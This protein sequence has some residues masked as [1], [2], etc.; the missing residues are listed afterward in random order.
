M[1]RILCLI[2]IIVFVP[3]GLL[4][5]LVLMLGDVFG[6]FADKT[7]FIKVDEFHRRR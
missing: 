7:N 3:L 6:W 1:K 4:Y 5:V 2:S